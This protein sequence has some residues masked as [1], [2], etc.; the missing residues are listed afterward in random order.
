MVDAISSYNLVAVHMDRMTKVTLWVA[1]LVLGSYFVWLFVDCA[2]DDT[3][4]LGCP[5]HYGINVGEPAHAPRKTQFDDL[6]CCG[7]LRAGRRQCRQGFVA[8]NLGLEAVAN[9]VF[10]SGLAELVFREP[11]ST[12]GKFGG[13]D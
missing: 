8:L 10:R 13:L 2:M 5:S 3:C 11:P 9:E 7:L 4:H 1:F 12:A 6:D